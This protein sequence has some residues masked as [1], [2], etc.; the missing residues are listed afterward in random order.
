MNDKEKPKII[1]KDQSS[2][3]TNNAPKGSHMGE[4][5]VVSD[6]LQVLGIASFLNRIRKN[7]SNIPNLPAN[8]VPSVPAVPENLTESDVTTDND[9]PTET[10]EENGVAASEELPAI[11]IT[12]SERK[13]VLNKK[14]RKRFQIVLIS[15]GVLLPIVAL[16]YYFWPYLTEPRP[17]GIDVVGSYN[18]KYITIENLENLIALEQAKERDHALCKIH[19]YNHEK[20]D[21]SEDCESHPIDSLE[22]YREM[23]TRLA[24]EQMIQDWAAKQGI[25]QREDVQ[26][27][28]KDLLGDANVSQLI[29]KIHKEKLTPE[30]IPKWEV[31]QYYDENKDTYGGKEFSE[32]EAEIRNILVSQ[33]DEE[34]FPEYIEELKKASGLEVNFDLLKVTEPTEAEISAY[35]RQNSSSYQIPEKAEVLEIKITS[36]NAQKTA[37]EAMRILRSGESF[38]SVATTYGQNGKAEKRYLE[39]GANSAAFE[40]IVW[41]MSPQEVSDPIVGDDGSVSIVKMVGISAAGQKSLSDVKAEIVDTLRK[42]NME[43]EYTLRKDEALFSV[44]S[45]RY[46]LGDFYTE[47]K[48]LSQEY[49]TKFSTFDTKKALLEQFIAKELLLEETGDSTSSAREQHSFDELKIQYLSQ[50]LHQEEVDKKIT[51]PTDEEMRQF[52]NKNQKQLITP[53]SVKVSLIWIDEGLNGEKA[54]QAL[55]KA[56]EA[57]SLLDSGTDFAEVAK[58]YSEDGTAP[59]GGAVDNWLYQDFLPVELGKPIFALKAGETSEII[60]NDFGIYIIKVRERVEQKQKSYEECVNEIKNHLMDEKHHQMESEMEKTLLKNAN[61]TVYDKTLRKMLIR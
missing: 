19:G 12:P 16:L 10:G 15:F 43:R 26:H 18:G 53:A 13:G 11:Q 59:A 1:N 28:L 58:K 25:T 51:D 27:G 4:G 46:T 47:F 5:S 33:K 38:E 9:A 7:K 44:H 20:C 2:K 52:Y 56:D 36:S 31:Q 23:V 34:F 22:G 49:Q 3:E 29:D 54:E 48:E 6:L 45:K 60:E 55:Q 17:P 14:T 30:S 24:V 50:I 57:R 8:P 37:E 32:V 40:S 39:R 41:K 42:E 21:P 61:F 35:Y